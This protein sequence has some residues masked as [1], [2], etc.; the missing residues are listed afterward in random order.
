MEL[1]IEF[2]VEELARGGNVKDSGE[3]FII[4]LG[5]LTGIHGG[6]IAGAISTLEESINALKKGGKTLSLSL[7]MQLRTSREDLML[8]SA[9]SVPQQL[10]W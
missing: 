5:E 8:L 2:I 4:S 9:L 10:T 1:T 7:A 6:E 3:G